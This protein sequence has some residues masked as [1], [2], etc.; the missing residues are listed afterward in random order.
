MF[1]PKDESG[2]LSFV[3]NDEDREL[4]RTLRLLADTGI[5][6]PSSLGW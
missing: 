5:G 4:A 1:P 2:S 3:H 6:M